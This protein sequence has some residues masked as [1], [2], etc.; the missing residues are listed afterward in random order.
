[1]NQ[2][3]IKKAAVYLFSCLYLALFSAACCKPHVEQP[4]DP[5]G[6]VQEQQT[7][8]AA[9]SVG[10]ETV[11]A[12]DAEVI[13]GEMPL[14]EEGAMM[15][16]GETMPAAEEGTMVI[17]G[18]MPSAEEGPMVVEGE[19]VEEMVEEVPAGQ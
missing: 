9:P 5:K 19:M 3:N 6:P 12:P 13:E 11:A 1:M 18:E 2:M 16:E 15:V 14:A 17:E 10:E 8:A 4:E 7:E